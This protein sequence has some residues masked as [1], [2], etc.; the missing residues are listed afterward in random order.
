MEGISRASQRAEAMEE[1]NL[2]YTEKHVRKKHRN[3]C[4]KFWVGLESPNKRGRWEA[5]ECYLSSFIWSHF[6]SEWCMVCRNTSLQV[7]N[8]L[9]RDAIP[10]IFK[11]C[12]FY[13]SHSIHHHFEPWFLCH[14]DPTENAFRLEE[15]IKEK[16]LW[17]KKS[18]EEWV[19][20]DEAGRRKCP[21]SRSSEKS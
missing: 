13:F 20:D 8:F 15:D 10:K 5:E 6:S 1:D 12:A 21:T 4:R 9:F 11:W 17:Q 14:H 3:K 19:K 7:C 2:H 18:R 16:P